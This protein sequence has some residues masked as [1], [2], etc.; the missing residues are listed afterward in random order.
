M[1]RTGYGR[2]AELKILNGTIFCMGGPGVIMSHELVEG[3]S[4]YPHSFL[5]VMVSIPQI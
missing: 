3:Q 1:G 4:K 2:R 5:H